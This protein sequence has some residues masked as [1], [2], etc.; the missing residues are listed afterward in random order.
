MSRKFAAQSLVAA[1]A[2]FSTAGSAVI[3][4]II[5]ARILGPEAN[6]IYTAIFSVILIMVTLAD[7]GV[8]QSYTTLTGQQKMDDR[9]LVGTLQ[10]LVLT[11]GVTAAL[12]VAGVFAFSGTFRYGYDLALLSL[13]TI[14]FNLYATYAKGIFLGKGWVSL[15]NLVDFTRAVAIPALLLILL[16]G[17]RAGT[18][19][20]VGAYVGASALAAAMAF[21]N[22]RRVSPPRF[23]WDRAKLREIATLGLKF[24]I[25][26]FF[27]TVNYRVAVVVMERMA[28]DPAKIGFYGVGVAIAEAIWQIPTAFGMV[29][30]SRSARST[31]A[32]EAVK[33]TL[34]V[35]RVTL[36]IVLVVAGAMWFIAP[37]FISLL[38][39][40]KFL[41]AVQA[42]RYM[43]PGVVFGVIFKILNSD[44]AARG[45]PLFALS[46]Y[47]LVVPLNIGLNIAL[48]PQY[49]FLGAAMATSISY[50]VGAILFLVQYCRAESVSPLDGLFVRRADLKLLRRKST[51][52]P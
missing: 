37:W 38:Y 47:A 27:I 7:M 42:T 20:M 16:L 52:A 14:P 13:A 1:A 5:I 46:V 21:W 35:L 10:S 43:L 23:D 28:V 26:L 48:I 33:R 39:G 34:T 45:K 3:A 40:D 32:G 18:M 15:V 31:D 11:N 24:A 8:R 4:G 22:L 6:G 29:L 19:G 12:V 49:D 36:P 2:R 9:T 51:K 44:L 25:A 50:A 30:M 41:P 17:F